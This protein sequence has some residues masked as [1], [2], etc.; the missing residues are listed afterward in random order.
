[1]NRGCPEPELD[2]I[3]LGGGYV[4]RL[5]SLGDPLITVLLGQNYVLTR[6]ANCCSFVD[7]H[8]LRNAIVWG[9]T[10]A[11]R[12]STCIP[13]WGNLDSIGVINA[14]FAKALIDTSFI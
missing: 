7:P 9:Q 8:K 2:T 6:L 14:S 4:S 10:F 1:M 13:D 3:T 11:V 12:H 5:P